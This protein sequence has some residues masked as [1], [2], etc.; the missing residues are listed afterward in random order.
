MVS[1]KRLAGPG[2][3]WTE[4]WIIFDFPFRQLEEALVKDEKGVRKLHQHWSHAP[5]CPSHLHPLPAFQI[6]SQLLLL[7]LYGIS[8]GRVWSW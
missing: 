6:P 3:S 5:S 7:L 2:D 4:Q 1:L 8:V